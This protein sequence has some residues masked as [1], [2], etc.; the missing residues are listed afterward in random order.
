MLQHKH[1]IVRAEIKTPPGP[2]DT[3]FMEQW[4]KDLIQDIGMNILMGPYVTYLD[5]EGNRGFTGV[6]IIE[7]SH[8]AMHVWDEDSPGLMQLDVYTCGE[9]D[10]NKVFFALK[11]FSPSKVEFKYLDRENFLNQVNEGEFAYSELF[12]Q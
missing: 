9:L 2:K 11:C 1:L 10:I 3:P 6:S 4:F 8:V 5:K 12:R 7:T